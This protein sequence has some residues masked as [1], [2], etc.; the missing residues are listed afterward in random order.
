MSLAHPLEIEELMVA[1]FAHHEYECPVHWGWDEASRQDTRDN[2]THRR[3]VLEL[4]DPRGAAGSYGPVK[5]AGRPARDLIMW[6]FLIFVSLWAIDV[7]DPEHAKKQ[8][9]A[10]FDLHKWFIRALAGGGSGRLD[11]QYELRDPQWAPARNAWGR[12]LRIPLLVDFPQSDV[13]PGVVSNGK[14]TLTFK[15]MPGGTP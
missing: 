10:I 7:S 14:A 11:S 3:I 5:Q 6:K 12:T 15:T 13:E 8:A 9:I 2:A 4:G 1:Y